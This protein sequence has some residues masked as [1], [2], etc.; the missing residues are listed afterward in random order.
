MAKKPAADSFTDKGAA[1]PNSL[2]GP[3]FEQFLAFCGQLRGGSRRSTLLLPASGVIAPATPVV[4]VDWAAGATSGTLRG[5][6]T[7]GLPDGAEVTVLIADAQRPVTVS[8]AAATVTQAQKILLSDGSDFTLV[9][10]SQNVTLIEAGG[11]WVEKDR[12]YGTA[13]GSFASF[14][15]IASGGSLTIATTAQGTAGAD[16]SSAMTPLKTRQALTNKGWLAALPVWSAPVRD[17]DALLYYDGA[18]LYRAAA[19]GGANALMAGVLRAPFSVEAAIVTGT[20]TEYAHG[21]GGVP[22]LH[23]GV[24]RCVAAGGDLGFAQNNEITTPSLHTYATSTTVGYVCQSP[25]VGPGGGGSLTQASW[26]VVLR[27]WARN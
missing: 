8:H 24:L 6:D 16:D 13:R 17:A 27:A 3:L 2:M 10:T 5:V 4:V 26:H 25:I 19:A 23:F 12:F 18:N 22:A 14:Y 21:L 9:S 1:R 20:A 11:G 7:S 15:G